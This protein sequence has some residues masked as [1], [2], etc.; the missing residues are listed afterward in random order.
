MH[1]LIGKMQTH[2]TEANNGLNH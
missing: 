2:H 1:V